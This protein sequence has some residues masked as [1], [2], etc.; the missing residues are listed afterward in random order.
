MGQLFAPALL[1]SDLV[2]RLTQTRTVLTRVHTFLAEPVTPS[3]SPNPQP[4]TPPIAIAVTD[5]S[6]AF[7]PAATILQI[8]SLTLNPG[9]ILAVIG[10][11]GSGKTTLG[12][13]LLRQFDP[14]RGAIR[15]NGVRLPELHLGSLRGAIAFCQ[16]APLFFSGTLRDN[17]RAAR[18]AANSSEIWEALRLAALHRVVT[19]LELGLDETIGPA[20]GRLSAGERQ[21]LA[22][23][24]ALLQ[25]ASVL[26][27]DEATS[28]LD[29]ATETQVMDNLRENL[30]SKACLFITHRT[31]PLAYADRVIAIRD[32]C[33]EPLSGTERQAGNRQLPAPA[34]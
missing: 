24:R 16:Q 20:A 5:I 18:P 34:S 14:Q 12:R 4:L 7:Q 30:G 19:S 17:L 13:L 32:G 21:R 15:Y 33:I 1:W 8:D 22:L 25:D 9:E 26:I 28:A 10:P 23:A 6:F 3:E 29:P 31:A 27:L 2:N 11:S